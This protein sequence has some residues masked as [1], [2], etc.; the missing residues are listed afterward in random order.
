MLDITQPLTKRLLL[1][2]EDGGTISLRVAYEK[3]PELY[4][5]CGLIRHQYNEWLEYKGQPKDELTYGVRM[6]APT[7][8]E[9][10]RQ[11]RDKEC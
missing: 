3:L 10:A 8:A 2:V 4:F 1:T 9:R 7:R 11:L 5:C 6:R